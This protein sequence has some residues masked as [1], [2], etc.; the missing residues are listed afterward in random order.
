MRCRAAALFDVLGHAAF[1]KEP[2]LVVVA[3]SERDLECSVRQS[4]VEGEPFQ[5]FK[6]G[7]VFGVLASTVVSRWYVQCCG[8]F[9]ISDVASA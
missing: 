8:Q 9:G 1:V 5:F 6:G 2:E 7:E 3:E 4:E